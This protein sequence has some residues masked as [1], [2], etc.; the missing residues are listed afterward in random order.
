MSAF[1]E[2][3]TFL[4]GD[5]SI[6]FWSEAGIDR[7]GEL[8]GS[9]AADD[10]SAVKAAWRDR[11]LEWQQRLAGVL[12]DGDLDQGLPLL[13]EMLLAPDD[14]LAQTAADTLSSGKLRSRTIEAGPEVKAQLEGL[15]RRR[16]GV[17]ASTDQDL[18]ARLH[19]RE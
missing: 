14:E 19:F 13:Q 5:Y 7:A 1:K 11:P 12:A 15:A 9:F 10:W 2:F 6:S 17:D 4:D 18:L 8:L 16:P 3:D